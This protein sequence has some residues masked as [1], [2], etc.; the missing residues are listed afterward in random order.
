M[1]P[2]KME[3]PLGIPGIVGNS[4]ELRKVLDLMQQAAPTLAPVLIHG[5]S[6]TGKELIARVLHSVSP[7]RQGPFVPLNCAA[8]PETLLES[9]LFGYERGSF[10][11]AYKRRLGRFEAANHGTLFLDEVGDI[12]PSLQ[13]KLLRVLQDGEIQR[14]GSDLSHRV[15]VRIVAA[16]HRNLQQ[17]V[18]EGRFREDLYY[19]LNV[20][21]LAVPPLR[22]RIEDV[23]FLINHFVQK[24]SLENNRV[25]K[26]I[27]GPTLHLL[28]AYR[29]PGNIRELENIMYRAVILARGEWITPGDLPQG[30]RD[31]VEIGL[32]LAVPRT[33]LELKK[34]KALARQEAAEHIEKMFLTKLL[35]RHQGKVSQAASEAG[36]NR[37]L[38]QQMMS[39]HRL[40]PKNFKL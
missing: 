23:P 14:I 16:T 38:L 15:D 13:A 17:W 34:A 18:K 19:R 25:I 4:E 2:Y 35:T 10:S 7:R 12:S 24:F 3:V 33:N 30:V 36:I 27:T 1:E 37:S 9:E 20:I 31:T 8:I 32:P 29:F 6:G 40:D 11:G 39:R 26:G 22:E 21:N 28:L 5:E